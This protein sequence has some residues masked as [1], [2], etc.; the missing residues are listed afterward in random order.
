M[1]NPVAG[2]PFGFDYINAYNQIS[3]PSTMHATNTGLSLYFQRQ[4]LQK[5][6]SPFKF[7]IPKW[8]A[9]NYFLY[10]L[11]VEGRVA[12]INTDRFGPICQGC[13]LGG[14][15]VFYQ[16]RY[17]TI[18]NP[19]IISTYNPIIGRDCT[20]IKLQPDYRG[21]YD[22]VTYYADLM[23]LCAQAGSVNILNS[24]LAYLLS[25][26][27]SAASETLKRVIDKIASGE[28]AVTVDKELF[29]EGGA[30][31]QI[32]TQNLRSNFIA[33]EIFA[34]LREISREFDQAVGIPT[35]NTEKKERLI[36]DE[37][38]SNNFATVSRLEL[39]KQELDRSME[40]TRKMF[41]IDISVEWRE[42]R[43]DNVSDSSRT[44]GM[45]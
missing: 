13:Q 19:L 4:L 37:V 16:P 44:D 34:L 20:L 36:V 7:T 30:E 38:N 42:G 21:V 12:V 11:Y 2:A 29:K 15:D 5:A 3:K 24:H 1:S 35:A 31:W 32:F 28:P 40:D 6:M 17:V 43:G 27:T 33:P 26:S 22:L 18:A 8:W 10:T 23:A 9:L 45:G 14:Y 25:A 39:W 41:N